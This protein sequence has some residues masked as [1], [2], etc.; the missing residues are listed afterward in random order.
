M[1]PP[2]S[3]P[4]SQFRQIFFG[5]REAPGKENGSPVADPP[6]T[7][8]TIGPMLFWIGTRVVEREGME[9]SVSRDFESIFG[10]S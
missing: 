9:I 7:E 8:A 5:W 6:N 10:W 4:L 2:S 3:S 1:R